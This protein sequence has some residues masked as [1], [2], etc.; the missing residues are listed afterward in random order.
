MSAK[1]LPSIEG[2]RLPTFRAA[3]LEIRI[4][5][6]HNGAAAITYKTVAQDMQ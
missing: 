2:H 6:S 3:A 5:W 4:A 1:L